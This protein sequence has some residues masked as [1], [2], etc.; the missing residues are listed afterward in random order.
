MKDG[1]I[2][3]MT[4]DHDLVDMNNSLNT[5]ITKEYICHWT[6]LHQV[7]KMYVTHVVG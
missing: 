6:T 3:L 7:Y 2:H 5:T 1:T 4:R